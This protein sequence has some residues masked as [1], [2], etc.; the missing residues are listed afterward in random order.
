MKALATGLLKAYAGLMKLYPARYQRTFGAERQEVFSLALE[1]AIR[2]GNRALLHLVLHELH[3]LPGSAIRAN[4]REWEAVMKTIETR[5]SEERLTWPGFLLGI[6][7]FLFAGPLI[8]ILPYLPRQTTRWFDFES[9][10]WWATIYISVFIGILVGWR[11]GFPSWVYPYLVFAFFAIVVPLLSWS[12]LL[13]P[14]GLS[15]SISP[16]ILLVVIVGLGASVLFLLSRL[17]PTRHIL[18]DIRNDWTLLSFGMFTFH[19]FSMGMYTG[20]HLPPFGPGVLLPS[21]VVVLGAV[22]YLFCRGWRV[23]SLVLI[24]TWVISFLGAIIFAGTEGWAIW[25]VLLE[26]SLIF[27]PA[28]IELIPG[29]RLMPADE[30]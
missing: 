27:S 13:V 30:G 19:A 1:E 15:P 17:P 23:R 24:A 5:P 26:A 6:W 10:L 9:P 14:L 7:P 11:K 28:L 16:V 21:V 18:A 20:D 8:A 12:G 25:P 4:L 3:D 2:L 22:T 29:P